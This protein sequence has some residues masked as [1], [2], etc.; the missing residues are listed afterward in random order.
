MTIAIDQLSD[1]PPVLLA[2]ALAVVQAQ[3][4]PL[5]ERELVPLA[6]AQGR[7]LAADV[8]ADVDLPPWDR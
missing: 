2:D 7:I 5:R 6:R 8:V 3:L 1:R 4:S